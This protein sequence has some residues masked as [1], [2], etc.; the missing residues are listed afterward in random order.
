L[1]LTIVM[2]LLVGLIILHFA[3]SKSSVLCI[4]CDSVT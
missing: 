4:I 2:V 3:I 1:H